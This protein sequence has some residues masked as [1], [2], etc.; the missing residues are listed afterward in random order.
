[1]NQ[2]IQDATGQGVITDIVTA[3]KQS[4]QMK[5]VQP[6]GGDSLVFYQSD[7]G[8]SYDWT[9]TLPVSGGVSTGEKILLVEVQAITQNV[10]FADLIYELYV[11]TST[12]RYTAQNYLA[13]IKLGHT[14]FIMNLIPQPLKISYQ[15]RARFGITIQGDTTTTCF[16]KFYAVANDQVS[17]TVTAKN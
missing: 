9:G 8:L 17:I 15:N 14:G 2:R 3:V 4:Q 10:L 6:I 5:G 7:S 16:A 12:N 13:D 1:M 11:G